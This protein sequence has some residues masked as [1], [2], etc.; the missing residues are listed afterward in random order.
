MF[1]A[2]TLPG[3][4]IAGYLLLLNFPPPACLTEHCLVLLGVLN[5]V[6]CFK[7]SFYSA[8]GKQI[9]INC[10]YRDVSYSFDPS[11]DKSVT[12]TSP[13]CPTPLNTGCP[14][15]KIQTADPN[16]AFTLLGLFHWPR[17]F[18]HPPNSH[19]YRTKPCLVNHEPAEPAETTI[20]LL[21]SATASIARRDSVS[22]LFF[23][24][25]LSLSLSFGLS[26]HR[27]IRHGHIPVPIREINRRTCGDI[28][29]Q[30]QRRIINL[31]G[32]VARLWEGLFGESNV[33]AKVLVCPWVS[34]VSGECLPSSDRSV[35]SG[36]QL[37]A[38]SL[39]KYR[40][41]PT[42]VCQD[43]DNHEQSLKLPCY[44][45]QSSIPPPP[46]QPPS[47]D[48]SRRF[49]YLS[50]FYPRNLISDVVNLDSSIRL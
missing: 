29:R 32:R 5:K 19:G 6:P 8:L 43:Y 14:E 37:N 33:L 45:L 35:P 11:R 40:G 26:F 4:S 13:L 10:S 22:L 25:L 2:F 17:S 20:N 36:F 16:E 48:S 7:Q 30:C 50:I 44:L 27:V 24:F 15:R 34:D 38:V 49:L 23:L 21:P 12:L 18:K 46:P 42:V 41:I 1:T 31:S 47:S 39:M 9:S 3:V 28:E